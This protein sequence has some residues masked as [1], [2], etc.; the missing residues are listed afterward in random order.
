MDDIWSTTAEDNILFSK[1]G[2]TKRYSDEQVK[3][4]SFLLLLFI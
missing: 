1:I 3:N 2:N 4:V